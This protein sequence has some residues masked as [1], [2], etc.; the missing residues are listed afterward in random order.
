VADAFDAFPLERRADLY[1]GAGLAATYAGAVDEAELRVFLD[2]GK[3]YL[4]QIAQASAF[5][6]TAR[7][8]AG[9]VTPHT[10][11]AARLLCG[12]TPE[13]AARICEESLPQP[14]EGGAVPGFELWRQRISS[15][16][17]SLQGTNK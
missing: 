11:L 2:R 3:A 8:R 6:A 9:L 17:M 12:V 14:S 1:C 13:D 4:P 16:L 15:T 10:E 5:A 7:V